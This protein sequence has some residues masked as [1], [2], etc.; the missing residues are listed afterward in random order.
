MDFKDVI[1]QLSER[2]EKLKDN[3]HTEEATKNALIMPM[4]QSLG[5][6]VFN[7]LEV[8]PEFVCDI[9]TKKGEKIDYAIMSNGIPILLIECKH[10]NQELTLH[11][12]QLLRYFHVSPAKFGLLTNGIIYKF[13][14]DLETPN[15]MDEKP[16]LEINMN[17][18]KQN[19]VDELKKFHKAY[20]DVDN[21]LSSAS[22]LKYT[23]E[24]KNVINK[25]FSNPS[26]EFVK[27]FAKQVYDGLITAKLLDQ[28]TTL[29][30]K[31]I[32]G[33]IND[34]ISDRLKTALKTESLAENVDKVEEKQVLP[35]DVVYM[36]EDG[37]IVTT[38]EEID[39]Y[40]IIKAILCEIVDLK[41]VVNRDTK[42][43]FGILFD[44][45]NR[46]PICRLYFNSDTTKYIATFDENKVETK[47]KIDNL[48]EI[49]KYAKELKNIVEFYLK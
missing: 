20:F 8:M 42:S 15:K 41:R 10:W 16:F 46:K 18:I 14:T 13:Y 23:N 9:G 7:P 34:T 19:Q 47:N 44:D 2:I 26:P 1:K 3:L 27:L 36:S 22:E 5:Y 30:R 12:N 45:N 43:Y 11:D 33:L 38:K 49:Y 39:G 21:I 24:L 31:S 40:N 28:F 32:S 6:D 37:N 35:D 25:E 4:L 29:V 17:D 48:N